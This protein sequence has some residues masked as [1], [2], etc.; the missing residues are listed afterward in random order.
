MSDAKPVLLELLER[1]GNTFMM[2]RKGKYEGYF[3][4][5]SIVEVTNLREG[6]DVRGSPLIVIMVLMMVCEGTYHA[7]TSMQ[8]SGVP[9]SEGASVT[10]R[11]RKSASGKRGQVRE[12]LLSFLDTMR[13]M[14]GHKHGS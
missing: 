6:G 14:L 9:F 3:L 2:C 8:S 12:R 13:D 10:R 7:E 4:Q 5:R 11:T 1:K